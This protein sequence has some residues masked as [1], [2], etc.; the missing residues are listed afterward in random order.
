MTV[1]AIDTIISNVVLV[2]K[3]D[4]L[5]PLQPL[6]SV[7]GGAIQFHRGPQCRYH[8]ENGAV[9]SDFRKCVSAVMKYLWHRRRI[10][11]EL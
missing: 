10:N 3:L 5:L 8:D 11:R 6:T 7:P 1:A 4:R 2:T 9:N